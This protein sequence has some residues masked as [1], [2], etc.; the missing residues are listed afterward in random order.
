MIDNLCHPCHPWYKPAAYQLFYMSSVKK[1]YGH[2]HTARLYQFLWPYNH[3]CPCNHKGLG[4]YTNIQF[5]SVAHPLPFPILIL[6]RHS[7]QLHQHMQPCFQTL[8]TKEGENLVHFIT[9]VTSRINAR[10][11]QLGHTRNPGHIVRAHD[12]GKYMHSY[13]GTKTA[14]YSSRKLQGRPMQQILRVSDMAPDR[15]IGK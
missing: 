10:Q 2:G 9:C 1:L 15:L 5:V 3:N 7:S 8:P 12:R 6:S 14:G 11:T 13:N 4:T